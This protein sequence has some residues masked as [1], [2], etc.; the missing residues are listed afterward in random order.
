MPAIELFRE[1]RLSHRPILRQKC[2]LEDGAMVPHRKSF[3]AKALR[4]SP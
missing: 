4:A 1:R 2:Q 3:T